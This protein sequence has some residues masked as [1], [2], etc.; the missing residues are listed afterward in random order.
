MKR[1][2]LSEGM[3]IRHKAYG[4]QYKVLD[5]RPYIWSRLCGPGEVGM[6]VK[7]VRMLNG[8]PAK[9]ETYMRLQDLFSEEDYE[10]QQRYRME[11]EREEHERRRQREEETL[12]VRQALADKLG[13][14]VS[15]V[16]MYYPEELTF[17]VNI[18]ALER[19]LNGKGKEV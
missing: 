7:V 6:D 19:F 11:R 16:R 1:K 4:Y 14:P 10:K 5:A 3:L 13:W 12:R 18:E 9:D 2:E 17:T 8:E 15:L